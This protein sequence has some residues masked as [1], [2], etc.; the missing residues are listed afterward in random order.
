VSLAG[1]S[2]IEMEVHPNRRLAVVQLVRLNLPSFT[3]MVARPWTGAV[4]RWN[5]I[6]SRSGVT[7]S[8]HA[9]HVTVT[10]Q[11]AGRGAS[12]LDSASRRRLCGRARGLGRRW[13]CQA[14]MNWSSFLL[15]VPSR[16]MNCFS[17]RRRVGFV[18][19]AGRTRR[20]TSM[21]MPGP[22][23]RAAT[24]SLCWIFSICG[25]VPPR[26]ARLACTQCSRISRTKGRSVSPT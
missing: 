21:C 18:V 5:N 6:T 17:H 10:I 16:R 19:P 4:S 13:M 12:T 11:G 26:M 9:Y 2:L 1:A 8:R 15:V 14:C 20:G 23:S 24:E 22:P 25:W 7:I 3:L